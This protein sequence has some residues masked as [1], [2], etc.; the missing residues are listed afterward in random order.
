MAK[1]K[2]EPVE[3]TPSVKKQAEKL[4]LLNSV[5]QGK[6]AKEGQN[7]VKRQ[8]STD[9]ATQAAQKALGIRRK[10]QTTDSNN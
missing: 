5:G 3:L 6:V 7:I 2:H 9:R 1:F 10:N 8:N 4:G